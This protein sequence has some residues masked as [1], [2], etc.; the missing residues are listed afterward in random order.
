MTKEELT[1]WGATQRL[2]D[3][4]RPSEPDQEVGAEQG[5]RSLGAKGGPWSMSKR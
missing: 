4:W 3:D 5:D 1:D 2:A